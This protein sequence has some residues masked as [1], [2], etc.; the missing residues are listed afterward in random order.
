MKRVGEREEIVKIVKTKQKNKKQIIKTAT[1]T[2][3]GIVH[4]C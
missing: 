1:K 3:E 2:R 4:E